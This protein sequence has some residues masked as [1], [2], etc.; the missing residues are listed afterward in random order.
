MLNEEVGDVEKA[1]GKAHVPMLL[2][3]SPFSPPH[4]HRQKKQKMRSGDLRLR[5]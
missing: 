4:T 5:D 3:K 1:H 2:H